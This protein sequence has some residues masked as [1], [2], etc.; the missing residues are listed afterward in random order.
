MVIFVYNILAV[1]IFGFLAWYFNHWW[2]VLFA[3]LFV[4]Y[5]THETKQI[6]NKEDDNELR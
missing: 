5:A 3:L 2:I 4:I 6:K 1:A